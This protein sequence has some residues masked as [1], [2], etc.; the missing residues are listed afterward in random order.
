M[1][2]AAKSCLEDLSPTIR[3]SK[4]AAAATWLNRSLD[5]QISNLADFY[6]QFTSKKSTQFVS[7]AKM[8]WKNPVSRGVGE[9]E[10]TKRIV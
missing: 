3:E 9:V 2:Y 6:M 8:K 1:T 5:Y 4:Q 10:V 7:A